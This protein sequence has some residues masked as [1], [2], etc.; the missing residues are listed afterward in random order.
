MFGAVSSMLRKKTCRAA[1]IALLLV[2][3]VVLSVGSASA[4]RVDPASLSPD[5]MGSIKVT[6]LTSG[7][8]I[9]PGG[10]LRAY[11]AASLSADGEYALTPAF[12]A[13]GLDLS[14]TKYGEDD[15]DKVAGYA[16]ANKSPCT[17][18]QVNEKGEAFFADTPQGIYL[19]T[20][21]EAPKGYLPILPFL[22]LVPSFTDGVQYDVSCSPKPVDRAPDLT[23]PLIVEKEVRVKRG[24]PAPETT[25]SFILTPEKEGQ[26]MPVNPENA[27]ANGGSAVILTRKG[28]GTVDFGSFGFSMKDADQTYV[29]TMREMRGTAP[30]YTYD[31]SVYTIKLHLYIDENGELACA[32]EITDEGGKEHIRIVFT[33]EYDKPKDDIPR[34]GQLWWPVFVLAAA[35]AV[36]V[37]VGVVRRKREEEAQ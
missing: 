24:G 3:S 8:E 13:C 32:R 36:L 6:V 35:G 22:V 19:I 4:L 15:A 33:N 27:S 14:K 20:Q 37:T 16:A 21:D 7:G 34:T 28:A 1:W 29:Y 30:Y 2:L 10:T 5:G 31:T 23:I 12:A 17:V 25:F 18:A 11:F 9:I 26:P